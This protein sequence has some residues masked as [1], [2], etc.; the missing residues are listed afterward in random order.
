MTLVNFYLITKTDRKIMHIATKYLKILSVAVFLSLLPSFFACNPKQEK[1]TDR[2]TLKSGYIKIAVDQTV[3]NVFEQLIDVFEATNIEAVIEPI[4]TSETNAIELLKKDSVR[5]AV[6]A[7]NFTQTELQYFKKKTF[8]PEAIRV[9]IDGIAL[10]TNP[11]NKDT[12]MSMK[13]LKKI[14]TG[15]ITQ[16]Q[17]IYPNSD[18]GKIQVVFD[19]TK[20]SLV[21]YANDSIC[22]ELPLS[23]KLNALEQNEQ[24]VNYVANNKNTLGIIGV[25]TISDPKDSTVVEFTKKINVMRVSHYEKT[26]VNNSYQPYQYYLY[27]QDYPMLREIYILL[28]DPRGELPKGFTR[29]VA[30][31]IGQRIIKKTGLLP[32]TMPINAVQIVD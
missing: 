21:R 23:D 12:I 19:N 14:L 24:V 29:F 10:I 1:E 5:L 22:R 11:V 31:Q 25:N 7:R 4:Y 8:R 27:T 30:G 26:D 9:A 6:T 16:W 28:N 2:N 3:Q 18:L 32:S 20:S 17:Q 15:E 13:N